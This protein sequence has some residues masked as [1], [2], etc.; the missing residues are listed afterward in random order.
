MLPD[1]A[2]FLLLALLGGW[3]AVDGT[4]W[5]Q[6]M[7][8]RPFVAATL[9]GWA[10]GNA[11]A[12]MTIGIVLEAFHLTVLPVGAARYPEGGPPAVVAGALFATSDL[13]YATLLILVV[14]GLGWEWVAGRSVRYLRIVNIRV[15]HG[16]G[17]GAPRPAAA[18]ERR[19]LGALL[20]DFA[21][22]V[23]LVAAGFV[24]QGAVLA[25]VAPLWSL[26][27]RLGALV[28]LATV[29]GL[30]ASSFRLFPGRR[31]LFVA[32]ALGALA[33]RLISA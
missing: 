25:L 26:D 29:A 23:L 14:L 1:P 15:V 8:S 12:G 18:L 33:F 21:R 11:P 7:I 19:H 17:F 30:L 24:L 4:S 3:V 10:V 13:S 22:G 5:G 31:G 27:E 9:A 2:L 20:L 28:V 32:G 6:F 16:D